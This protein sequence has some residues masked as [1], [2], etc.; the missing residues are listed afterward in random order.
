[1][2]LLRL[3]VA[4]SAVAA[5]CATVPTATAAEAPAPSGTVAAPISAK[6]DAE[7]R[8]FAADNSAAVAA[9]TTVCGTGYEFTDAKQLP[10][11]DNRYGTLFF[12]MKGNSACAILD[13]NT[14]GGANY[15]DL[16]MYPGDTPSAGGRD[17][18]NFSEYA[19]P[20]YSSTLAQG[21]RCVTITAL[22][23]N[24]AGTS[25]LIN[26]KGGYVFAVDSS[27]SVCA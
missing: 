26:W 5:V 14:P 13:N 1:M 10:N 16:K 12:Y 6:A 24:E 25:N 8:A 20:V 17:Y 27:S 15:M 3:V 7:A 4:G 23:K 19:G 22:M 2:N 11:A 21:G 9:A 18:G